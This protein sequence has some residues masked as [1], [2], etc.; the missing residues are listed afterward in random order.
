MIER[1]WKEGSGASMIGGSR[2]EK[3]GQRGTGKPW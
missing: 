3:K 1:A 2:V